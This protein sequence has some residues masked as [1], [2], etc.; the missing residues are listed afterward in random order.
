MAMVTSS[1]V[2][3]IEGE[4]DPACA[5]EFAPAEVTVGEGRTTVHTEAIDQP[6][7]HGILDRVADLGLTLLSV[8]TTGTAVDTASARG[9][10]RPS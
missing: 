3:V 4:V 9:A 5:V 2:I 6:G 7:L 10:A 1:Y 8:N